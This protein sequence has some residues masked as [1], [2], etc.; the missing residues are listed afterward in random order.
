MEITTARELLKLD[1]H[2]VSVMYVEPEPLV[3]LD[4]LADRITRRPP[5][6][7]GPE[8]VAVQPPG[9]QYHGKARPVLA[10][11]CGT[12]S[13]G[14]GRGHRQ[15]DA[16]ERH[17][18]DRRFR[19][20]ARQRLD[21]KKHPGAGHRGKFACWACFRD[22]WPASWPSAESQLLNYLLTRFELK[23]DLTPAL[24]AASIVTAIVIA[25][26]AGLY[27]AWRASRMTPMDAIRNE[28]S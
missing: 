2:Y 21:A 15:H 20:D 11:D 7:S 27:P 23:L 14:R 6:R 16:D 5:R 22:W 4:D 8:H 17:G 28:A 13:A 25:T 19:R 10:L 24:V 1:K 12:G 9:R 3:D 18:A 26:L